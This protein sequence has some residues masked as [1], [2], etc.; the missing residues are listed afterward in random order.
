MPVDRF[1][2]AARL[3]SFGTSRLIASFSKST[4]VITSD[5]ASP[6]DCSERI[7]MATFH[8]ADSQNTR[9][10]SS[11]LGR[12]RTFCMNQSEGMDV[13]FLSQLQQDPRPS[14]GIHSV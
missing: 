1:L 11:L 8:P 9:R 4:S 12:A 13:V 7:P 10:F 5:E 14:H 3:V 6:N 2:G